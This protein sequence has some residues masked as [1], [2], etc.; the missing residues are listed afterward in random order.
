MQVSGVSRGNRKL[1][2]PEVL[3]RAF[4]Y[5]AVSRSLYQRLRK[6]YQLPSVSTLARITSSSTKSSSSEFLKTVFEATE[7]TRKPCVLLHDE[8]YIKKS[9]QYHGGEIFGK[10]VNDPSLL[11]ETMLGQMINC[12]HGG[13]KFLVS[14]LPVAKM[15]ANFLHEELTKAMTSI[16]QASGR[17]KAVISD[18]NRTNQACFK[19][20][21]TVEG[22]PWLTVEGTYLLYDFV[23]LIKNIR[24]LWLTE[25][26]TQLKFEDQGKEYIADFQHVRA[27]Y[28]CEENNFFTMS[29]LDE[30]SVYPKPIERQRIEPC[31]KVFSEKVI[32]ALELWGKDKSVDVKG[33]VLFIKKV[34][35]W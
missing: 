35:N 16:E 15:N 4:S 28:K 30:V 29:G 3:V 19:K 21:N 6:D 34:L 24:N 32:V 26:T 2:T 12:L 22:K 7:N 25:K 18:A 11:A 33:T 27:L 10:A 9:L 13:N 17:L 20:Y 8:V 23:H 5:Y 31:L 1:Y 14:M